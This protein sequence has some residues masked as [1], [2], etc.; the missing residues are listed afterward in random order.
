MPCF[1]WDAKYN[2]HMTTITIDTPVKLPQ[3]HFRDMD[4]LTKVLLQWKFEQELDEGME[5]A[6]KLP[7]SSWQSI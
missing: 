4:E 3:S 5:K 1:L 6:K 7:A 2:E